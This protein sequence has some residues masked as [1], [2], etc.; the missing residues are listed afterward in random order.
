[1][2]RQVFSSFFCV[3]VKRFHFWSLLLRDTFFV[4][5]IFYKR[6]SLVLWYLRVLMVHVCSFICTCCI[7]FY[8][9]L[10]VA[11]FFVLSMVFIFYCV[12]VFLLFVCVIVFV[13]SVL[14]VLFFLLEV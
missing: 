5:D 14:C 6:V 4:A 2:C 9:S 13:W 3:F 11:C 12:F 1:M 8:L 7:Y 10:G